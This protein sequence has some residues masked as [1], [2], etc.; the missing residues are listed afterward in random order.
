VVCLCLA[1]LGWWLVR[2]TGPMQDESRSVERDASEK[3]RVKVEMGA[4]ILKVAGGSPNW[5]EGHFRYNVP[6][7]KPNVQ[8]A[9]SGGQ[10]DLTIEQST[11]WGIG[12]FGKKNE[13]DLRLNDKIPTNLT[14]RVGAGEAR[15][16]LG[17]LSLRS[18]EI[19]TG[20]GELRLDLRGKPGRSYDVRIRGGA[21]EVTVQLPRDVGVYAR[22]VGGL[23][24][25]KVQGLRSE[26]DHWV[27]DAYAK[28]RVKVRLDVQG[29]VGAITLIAE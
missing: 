29:G 15:L 3:L 6:A 12:P 25:V 1:V 22:A 18:L 24:E 19:E 2:P 23:G 11:S 26:G 8:Y 7:W 17:A 5:L 10:G 14:V 28:S 9:S 16:D 27:N 13:W 4:G 20:A 21:G